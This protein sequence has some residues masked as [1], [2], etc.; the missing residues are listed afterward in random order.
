MMES[1]IYANEFA[2]YGFK[3]YML[4]A[5]RDVWNENYEYSIIKRKDG[6]MV[7]CVHVPF[8]V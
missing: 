7:R 4:I 3:P 5:T 1:L 2:R 6:H 8:D